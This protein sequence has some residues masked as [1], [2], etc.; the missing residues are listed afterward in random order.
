[1]KSLKVRHLKTVKRKIDN[2]DDLEY[3][4]KRGIINVDTDEVVIDI[5]MILGYNFTNGELDSDK[6]DGDDNDDYEEEDIESD[7]ENKLEDVNEITNKCDK[8]KISSGD[9]D[10]EKDIEK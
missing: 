4:E 6:D 10:N 5:K 8:I 1:M 2:G 3:D 9:S 7:E